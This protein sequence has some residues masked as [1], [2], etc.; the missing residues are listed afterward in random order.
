MRR[1]ILV[2][3]LLWGSLKTEASSLVHKN[4]EGEEIIFIKLGGS[5]ITHK[6][7]PYTERPEMLEKLAKELAKLINFGIPP[8][9]QAVIHTCHPCRTSFPDYQ[10]FDAHL[11]FH[12]LQRLGSITAEDQEFLKGM[13]IKW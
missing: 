2:V 12:A 6:M 11:E 13:L 7:M 1:F 3:I 8:S 10:S 9:R 5:L 4:F